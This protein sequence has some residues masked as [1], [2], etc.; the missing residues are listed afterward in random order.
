MKMQETPLN[1]NPCSSTK[2]TY[3]TNDKQ[4]NLHSRTLKTAHTNLTPLGEARTAHRIASANS[5][6]YNIYI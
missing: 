2:E 5:A 4:C 3:E 6:P 1:N